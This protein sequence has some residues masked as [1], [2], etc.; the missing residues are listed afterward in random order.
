GIS[1]A[2]TQSEIVKQAAP[3]PKRE[4]IKPVI[5]SAPKEE[6]A[7]K[8]FVPEKAIPVF[9]APSPKPKPEPVQQEPKPGWF[10]T[11]VK[12]NPDMEKFIGENLINKIG[13]AVL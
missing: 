11:W 3:I 10:E 1:S 5:P 4:E 8:Q 9:E 2:T 6:V 13:I 12:N 7:Q